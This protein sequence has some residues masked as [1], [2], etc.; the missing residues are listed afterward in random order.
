MDNW[1]GGDEQQTPNPNHRIPKHTMKTDIPESAVDSLPH[2]DMLGPS[3]PSSSRLQFCVKARQ[4][5]KCM[6]AAVSAYQSPW[7]H[8]VFNKRQTLHFTSMIWH[9]EYRTESSI[10]RVPTSFHE[11]GNTTRNTPEMIPEESLISYRPGH[12]WVRTVV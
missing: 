8:N 6:S 11:S 3:L 9:K 7:F 5:R 4:P 10:P 1:G 2:Q 12:F